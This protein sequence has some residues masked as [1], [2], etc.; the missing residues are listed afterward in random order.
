MKRS[1]FITFCLFLGLLA[2]A[3]LPELTLE[4]HL[5]DYDFAVKYIE[6]NY[7]GFSFWVTDSSRSD[8]EVTK[9][10][11]RGEVERGERPGWDAVAAYTGW[12]NDLHLY[13]SVNYNGINQHSY[14]QRHMTSY[15]S[16]MEEYEPKPVAIKVTDKTFLVRFP[17]CGGNPDMKWIKK[18]IK[19]Y[20]KSH[21]KNRT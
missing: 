8:Y 19:Q 9:S 21:C 12:F 5:E 11:L 17:S 18:S 2:F 4:Q 10:R 7:S 15:A 6:D 13:L 3:Q 14:H 16:Q 20:K 1:I